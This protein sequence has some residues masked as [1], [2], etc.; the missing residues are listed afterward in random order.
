MRKEIKP[1]LRE[2]SQNAPV[3]NYTW[4]DRFFE[5]L[6]YAL[7]GAFF[8]FVHYLMQVHLLETA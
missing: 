4:C 6:K 1:L 5:A 3:V 7:V 8:M 2:I